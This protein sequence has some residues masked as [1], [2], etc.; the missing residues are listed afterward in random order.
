MATGDSTYSLQLVSPC[1]PV[2]PDQRTGRRRT[3]AARGINLGRLVVLLPRLADRID[4]LP[5]GVEFVTTHEQRQVA[6]QHVGKQA[7]I[8]IEPAGLE[9]LSEIQAQTHRLQAH[10]L[11]RTLG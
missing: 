8:S 4:P 2:P 7:L 11:A 10:G 5:R 1:K 6:L 9:G 3:P